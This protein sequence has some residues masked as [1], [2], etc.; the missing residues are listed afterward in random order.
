MLLLPLLILGADWPDGNCPGLA[1]YLEAH[2]AWICGAE[3]AILVE[4]AVGE[5]LG[6][7]AEGIRQGIGAGVRHFPAS[8]C[9]NQHKLHLASARWMDPFSTSPPRGAVSVCWFPIWPSSEMVL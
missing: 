3:D 2:L 9:L 1:S 6:A 8:S 7:V 4:L 5:S